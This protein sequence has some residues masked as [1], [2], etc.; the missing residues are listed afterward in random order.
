M[1]ACE[2]SLNYCTQIVTNHVS[3]VIQSVTDTAKMA[4]A[5]AY[6]RL[7]QGR[8]VIPTLGYSWSSCINTRLML[9]R[10]EGMR[11][12]HL[13]FSPFAKPGSCGY[14][15]SI[16]GCQAAEYNLKCCMGPMTTQGKP[17][18]ELFCFEESKA[19]PGRTKKDQCLIWAKHISEK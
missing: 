4:F 14:V 6:G 3:D 19:D 12:A 11:T 7:S 8:R 9:T 15:I 10:T 5:H 16:A 17:Q 13:I 18:S 2:R 1:F